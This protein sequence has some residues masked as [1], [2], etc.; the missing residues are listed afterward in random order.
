MHNGCIFGIILINMYGMHQSFMDHF[1]MMIPTLFGLDVLLVFII[2]NPISSPQ[3]Q[4]GYVPNA[5][6]YETMVSLILAY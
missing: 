3:Q 6:T 5:T 4:Q 1:G 2:G